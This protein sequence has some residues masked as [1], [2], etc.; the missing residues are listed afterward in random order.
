MNIDFIVSVTHA[1]HALNTSENTEKTM[2]YSAASIH[3]C[4]SSTGC[5]MMHKLYEPL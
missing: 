2:M 1:M 3:T 5:V 4:L